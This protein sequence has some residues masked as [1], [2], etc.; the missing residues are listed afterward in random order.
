MRTRVDRRNSEVV[1]A[2]EWGTGQVI[3]AIV[4]LF[5]ALVW[6]WLV[7][8]VLSD[9][10]RSPDLSGLAK[11]AWTVFVVVMPVLGGIVYVT[12]RGNRLGDRPGF[13]TYSNWRAGV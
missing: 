7:I 3:L 2:V 1:P 11:A 6:L 4:L 12:V 13:R 10:F 9:V 5:V 8:V